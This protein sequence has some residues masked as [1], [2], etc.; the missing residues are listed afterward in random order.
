M[1]IRKKRVVIRTGGYT[2]VIAMND[3]AEL[4]DWFMCG[5]IKTVQIASCTGCALTDFEAQWY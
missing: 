3:S 1:V 2:W 5:F 4:N